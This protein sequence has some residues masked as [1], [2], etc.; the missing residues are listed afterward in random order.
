MPKASSAPADY[1][2][3]VKAKFFVD[4]L[5]GTGGS[6]FPGTRSRCDHCMRDWR[7][8]SSGAAWR[9]SCCCRAVLARLQAPSGGR[10]SGDAA[11]EGS[12]GIGVIFSTTANV[13]KF[14]ATSRPDPLFKIAQG[15][16]MDSTG[17]HDGTRCP[18]SPSIKGT[19]SGYSVGRI[20]SRGEVYLQGD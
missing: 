8:H 9:F 12:G 4:A 5:E 11:V 7:P 2:G 15:D 10:A 19:S 16:E 20:A 14:V 3:Q 18:I 17:E 6:W 1:G 13:K